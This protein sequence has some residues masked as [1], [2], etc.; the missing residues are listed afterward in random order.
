MSLRAELG[1]NLGQLDLEVELG[2][3]TGELVVLL[4]PNG[5]G[6]TTLLR[7]LAGLVPLDRGR[8]AG[9]GPAL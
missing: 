2:V 7:A 3:A 9:H 5:A 4:G 6:K 1:L 8:A